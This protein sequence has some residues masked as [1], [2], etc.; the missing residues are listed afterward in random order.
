MEIQLPEA[1]TALKQ[2]AGRLIRDTHD[3]GVLVIGDNRV[4]RK[5]YGRAFINSLPP[6]PLTTELGDVQA[7]FATADAHHSTLAPRPRTPPAR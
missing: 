3:R 6:M 1:I 4:L 5:S 7:F 2:G